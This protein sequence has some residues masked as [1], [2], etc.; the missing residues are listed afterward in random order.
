[1]PVAWRVPP[2]KVGELVEAA[3][4]KLLEVA[5]L[6]VP[7]L[8]AT[9]PVRVLLLSA[10][11][12]TVPAPTFVSV[13]VAPEVM[14]PLR[15]RVWSA[16]ATPTELSDATLIAPESDAVPTPA[17]APMP[18]APAPLS[19]TDSLPTATLLICRVAALVTVVPPAVLPRPVALCTSTMPACTL[20]APA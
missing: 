1:M 18:P 13:V 10:E 16:L 17:S 3:L 20:V 19:V 14:A 6:S 5:T 11:S 12:T 2:F 8:I 15:V 9:G 4:P 7:A